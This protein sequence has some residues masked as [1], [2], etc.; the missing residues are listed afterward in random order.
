MNFPARGRTGLDYFPCRYGTSKL[1]F[2]GPRRQ[3]DGPYVAMLGGTET[4]GR[5]V[6]NPYPRLVEDAT[7]L[8]TV[9]LG[10]QN[11]G[12]DVFL[13]D[14][15]VMEICRKAAVTVIQ[16]PGAQNLTN[17]FYSVHPRRNDRFLAA[18]PELRQLCPDL[19]FAEIH[20]TRHLMAELQQTSSD[21]YLSVVDTLRATWTRQMRALIE[22]AGRNV[23][24]LWIGTAPPGTGLLP[25][26][27]QAP[28]PLYVTRGMLDSLRPLVETV[29]EVVVHEPVLD[30]G[31]LGMV[32]D[33]EEEAAAACSAN[34]I[35]HLQVAEALSP[36]L[37]TMA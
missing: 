34:P 3:L 11:A 7:G 15:S 32:H 5:F 20:F 25:P 36:L 30:A 31:P 2:R 26:A 19:D 27:A 8:R 37:R 16:I 17:R 6:E 14:P 29:V 28:D 1:L 23:V 18:T 13:N 9:N 12:V 35:V 24:L 33:P 4:Y 21:I 10:C 22:Q